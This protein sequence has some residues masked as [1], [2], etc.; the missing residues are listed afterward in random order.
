MALFKKKQKEEASNKIN[1]EEYRVLHKKTIK[2][3]IAPSG[4]DASKLD[5]ME[6]ISNVTRYARSFF[7][8]GLQYISIQYQ[9]KHLKKI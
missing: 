1:E 2:E 6:I 4:I 3:I 5:Y 8:S 9:K 7:V